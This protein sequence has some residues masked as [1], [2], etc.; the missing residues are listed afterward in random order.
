M[1]WI[2]DKYG[3]IFK[4]LRWVKDKHK[5]V[6]TARFYLQNI[7][8]NVN[9]SVVTENRLVAAW[10]QEWRRRELQGHEETF[11][12]DKNVMYVDRDSCTATYV[13]QVALNCVL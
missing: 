10:G 4:L 1:N 2:T 11:E 7:F 6:H 8:E 5:S 9:W 3:W 12:G 13:C